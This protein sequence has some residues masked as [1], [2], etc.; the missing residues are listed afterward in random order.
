MGAGQKGAS[1]CNANSYASFARFFQ[2]GYQCSVYFHCLPGEVSREVSR[3]ATESTIGAM[4]ALL[5][6]Y[7]KS[8]ALRLVTA[9]MNAL[10]SRVI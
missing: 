10:G 8:V 2:F 9:R 5:L 6:I 4:N 3:K 1:S 7:C